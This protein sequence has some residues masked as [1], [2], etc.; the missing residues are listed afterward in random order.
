MTETHIITR[1]PAC[2]TAFRASESQLSVREGRVRCGRCATVFDARAYALPELA[3]AP[4][5]GSVAAQAQ[6]EETRTGVLK[7][8]ATLPEDSAAPAEDVAALVENA[9]S[10]AK[11]TAEIARDHNTRPA[12]PAEPLVLT[13]TPSEALPHEIEP[14]VP[15][16]PVV[17]KLTDPNLEFDFGRPRPASRGRHRWLAVSSIFVLVVT[18][19]LQL[20]FYFRGDIALLF[21]EL[22]PV[23]EDLCAQAG[24]SLP[25]PQRADMMSIE[26]SDLQADTLNPA[27]MVLSA[28]LRNRA[29]F[30]QA[31]PALEL[32]LTDARDQPLA[33]RVLTA[34]DYA[35]RTA[36]T[37]GPGEMAEDNSFAPGT[38]LPIKVYFDASAVQATGY[39]LYLFYP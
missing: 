31:R 36:S 13:P 16:L 5:T 8:D 9:S 38:E 21:P 3:E 25:L 33:R 37:S 39:R 14:E 23:M 28:T 12:V 17:I 29:P 19:A 18:L 32:T 2:A 15:P 27:V 20:G 35:S 4:P 6:A 10:P 1:C 30:A 22:K 24:C 34:S 11:D 7:D 26:S